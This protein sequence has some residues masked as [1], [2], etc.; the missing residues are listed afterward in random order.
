MQKEWANKDRYRLSSGVPEPHVAPLPRGE[1]SVRMIPRGPRAFPARGFPTHSREGIQFGSRVES[2]RGEF[3]GR[4]PPHG[5]YEARRDGR[6][7][8]SQRHYGSHFRPRGARIPPM[9]LERSPPFRGERIPPLRRESVDRFGLIGHD[10]AN[11]TFEQMARHWFDSF[12][13]NPSVESYARS[14]S[15]F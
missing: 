5:R 2:R 6:S 1:G 4:S 9:R 15:H 3:A 7:F 14:R 12:C 10:F 8:E 13:A 11:P